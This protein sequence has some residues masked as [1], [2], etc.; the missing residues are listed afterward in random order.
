[1]VDSDYESCAIEDSGESNW[2]DVR[3]PTGYQCGE[4]IVARIQHYGIRVRVPC[5]DQGDGSRIWLH[6]PP[7]AVPAIEAL[8]SRGIVP[9]A[10]DFGL[11]VS[12]SDTSS[13]EGDSVPETV[14]PLPA[15]TG[16]VSQTQGNTAPDTQ[17]TFVPE[18]VPETQGTVIPESVPETR[19][20]LFLRAF[21]RHKNLSFPKVFPRHEIL[22]FL[23]RKLKMLL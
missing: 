19:D 13:V 18:S 15:I 11:I 12:L 10:V 1:M 7:S 2:F 8:N 14:P 21:P 23:T 5:P 20:M 16:F 17:D 6:I 4:L 9:S 22:L 3:I